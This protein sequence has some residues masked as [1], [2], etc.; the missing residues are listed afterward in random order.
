VTAILLVVAV[1]LLLQLF[2]LFE[3]LEQRLTTIRAGLLDRAPTGQVAIVEIDAK[4]LKE[5][6]SW[7][8]SRRFHAEA[9][10]QLHAAGAARV[11]FDVDFSSSSDAA[12]DRAFANALRLDQSTILPVFQQPASDEAS[13]DDII[14]TKPAAPFSSAWI[15]GVNIVPDRDG[16]VRQYPAATMIAGQIRPSMAVLLAEND[17][18]GDRTFQPD[19]GIDARRIP[20]FSFVDVLKGRVPSRAIAGKH[21]LIGATAIELGDRYTIPRLGT[22][23][24]VVVQA[25]ATES[26]LQG[27]AI[28]RSGILFTILGLAL[29]GAAFAVRLRQGLALALQATAMIALITAVPIAVQARWPVS[30]DSA[31]VLIC[32]LGCIAARVILEVRRRHRET[33]LVDA[34]TGLPNGRALE[35]RLHELESSQIVLAAAGIDRFESIRDAM[36]TDALSDLVREISTRIEAAAGEKVYRIAPDVLAWVEFGDDDKDRFR[37]TETAALFAEPVATREGPVDV[38]LTVGMDDEAIDEKARSKIERSVAAITMARAANEDFHWYQSIDPNIRRQLSLMG[39]LRRGMKQGEVKVAYQPKLGIE[40]GTIAH[41]EALVRWHHPDQG[42]IPPD[43]FI[44]LAESTGVVR[45]LTAHVLSS[46]L[47]DCAK[48][49]AAGTPIAVA[50]NVSAADF[51]R[52]DF[53]GEIRELIAA[54]SA[55]PSSLTLEVTES[56]ILTSPQKAIDALIA[57]REMGVRLAVDDYGTGQSTLSYLKQL[58]VHELKIDKSFVTTMCDN[59]NDRI[60]VKSTIDLA[61]ELGMKVVAEGVEEARTLTL[62]RT[63]GCDYAQGYLIGQAMPFEQLTEVAR[64][65]DHFRKVA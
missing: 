4:S 58:P 20:R 11:G 38:H 63:L 27:R 6:S 9:L 40:R 47:A 19:W 64:S 54:W 46:A 31:A 30:L 57:L 22:V 51:S 13:Q 3:P 44:P 49:R 36:S 10:E 16:V 14:Q 23:P 61:H 5:I 28:S 42:V 35:A 65:P 24:G 53:V 41:A 34:E 39:E 50:V 2:G 62:L 29:T 56:A 32:A 45:E 12:G 18:L 52:G 43:I 60:M 15:G 26:L 7:P 8:W 59:E 37:A 1:T 48:M 21:I 25:L 17:N 33:T 55:N